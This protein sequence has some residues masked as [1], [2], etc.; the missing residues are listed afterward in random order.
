FITALEDDASMIRCLEYGGDDFISKP[1]KTPVLRAKIAAME[2]IS[3]LQN[4]VKDQHSR[5][6]QIHQRNLNE[7]E[8]AE[9]IFNRVVSI[10][11]ANP[12]IF[13]SYH[14]PAE[15][16]NGD[17]IMA[18]KSPRGCLNVLV[19]DFTGHGI[20]SAMCTM[21]VLDI[22]VK[23]TQKGYGIDKI[24][25]EIGEKISIYLP[26]ERFLACSLLSINWK[27]KMLKVWN[28]GMP[29][30]YVI[31]QHEGIRETIPSTKVPLGIQPIEELDTSLQTYSLQDGDKIFAYSDGLIDLELSENERFGDERLKAFLEKHATAPSFVEPI[32]NEITAN[33]SR[34]LDD[35]TFIEVKCDFNKLAQLDLMPQSYHNYG[36]W[37]FT[38]KL[39]VEAMQSMDPVPVLLSFLEDMQGY[40]ARRDSLFTILSEMYSNALE[41]GLL[42]IQSEEKSDAK[43][44]TSYYD[45]VKNRLAELTSGYIVVSF[46]H[47]TGQHSNVLTIAIEDSGAGFDTQ[48]VLEKKSEDNNDRAFGRGLFL[49]QS[50][51]KELWFNEK[52]NKIHVSLELNTD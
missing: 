50:L 48:A 44:F 28:G 30:I 39:D 41:H 24:V 18:Q 19:G 36:N 26:T 8:V 20:A 23:M 34:I 51:S 45:T 1:F 21:P 2:R 46:E 31:G 33:A 6:L 37:E 47:K 13:K 42:G 32:E 17:I 7:M 4:K 11:D 5:L 40:R 3:L 16:F 25:Q 22:F 12:D 27:D 35:I 52:G 10:G 49:I 15:M 29:D 9:S 14:K 43:G 38:F